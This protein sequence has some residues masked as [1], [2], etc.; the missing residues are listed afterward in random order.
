[1]FRCLALSLLVGLFVEPETADPSPRKTVY[2]GKTWQTRKPDEVGLDAA[3]LEQLRD[4][5]G[6]RGCVVR[7]GY[8]VF[9]WGDL[10]KSGDIASAFKPLLS[11]LLMLALQEGRLKSVDDPVAHFEPRLKAI[12]RG[13]ITWRH[14]ASQT[15][16][17]GLTEPPGKAYAYN[18]YA[19]ALYYDTLIQ[20]VFEGNGNDVLKSRLAG[21]LQFE[22]RHTFEAF[23]AKDRPGRLALSV[24]DFARFGLL[25]LREGRWRDKQI[26][27][28]D[29]VKLMLASP[30]PA[31]TPLT[32]ARDGPMLPGQRT[33]GGG[34]NI[35]RIGP[36]YYS[37]NWWLNGKDKDGRRLFPDAPPDTI[38]ASGHGGKRMLWLIPSLDLI[39]VWND[40]RVNDHDSSPSNPQ[41][42]CN[43]AAR[44][45]VA[46]DRKRR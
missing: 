7:H 46:A 39:V 6:G 12:E 35:T 9:A 8:L 16:G 10:A 25:V 44:L 13:D 43:Q 22:D 15:S 1:M 14:L 27:R 26:V 23:G 24:R 21:P 17:Y 31:D 33:I 37:F 45:L 29:L 11:T 34:K 19:L 40:S 36:G 4:L 38:V 32:E 28:K 5:V 41:T 2:P 42:K 20:K 3:K 18:D 30:L